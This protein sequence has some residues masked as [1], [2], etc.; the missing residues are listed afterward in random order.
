MEFIE[1][2]ILAI[3][4]A[5]FVAAYNFIKK[6]SQEDM[7]AID[8]VHERVLKAQAL[9]Q[10]SLEKQKLLDSW[11]SFRNEMIFARNRFKDINEINCQIEQTSDSHDLLFT[12]GHFFFFMVENGFKRQWMECGEDIVKN[13][14]IALIEAEIRYYNKSNDRT[15][16]EWIE[17]RPITSKEVHQ[18]LLEVIK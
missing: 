1:T 17:Y 18:S 2:I 12:V 3:I 4:G 6:Q 16:Q 11:N 8:E 9:K 14:L 15:S 13:N 10:K 7:N 5:L